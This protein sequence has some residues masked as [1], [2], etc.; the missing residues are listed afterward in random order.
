LAAVLVFFGFQIA[1]PSFLTAQHRWDSSTLALAGLCVAVAFVEKR[2]PWA[3]AASGGLLAMAAW[4][5]PSVA[6][7]GIA[8][9][10]W[11]AAARERR[12]ALIPFN[13]GVLA[14]TAVAVGWLAF[15]GT[16]PAFLHQMLWLQRNYGA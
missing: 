6:L 1:D 5:T 13:A 3:L 16:L 11:L 4:C 10:L 12:K 9:A 8:Q 14:V 2:S 7:V 15:T